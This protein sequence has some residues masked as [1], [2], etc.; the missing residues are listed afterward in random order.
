VKSVLQQTLKY[1]QRQILKGFRLTIND[2]V[3]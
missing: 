2:T 1:H 3:K